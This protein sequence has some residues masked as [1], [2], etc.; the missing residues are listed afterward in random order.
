MCCDKLAVR[1]KC[2]MLRPWRGLVIKP[3][4]L[5]PGF[6]IL[7]FKGIYDVDL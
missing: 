4:V 1:F 6:I 7:P 3:G 2:M 5:T